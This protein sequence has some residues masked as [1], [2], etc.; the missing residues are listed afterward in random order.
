M[1]CQRLSYIV[2]AIPRSGSSLL[3]ELLGETGVAGAPAEYFGPRRMEKLQAEWGTVGLDRYVD[4]LR[5]RN[6]GSNGVFGFK[7]HFTQL[8]AAFGEAGAVTDAFP[9]LRFVSMRRGD[10]VRQAVSYDRAEQTGR[11]SSRAPAP[12][13]EP[14]FDVE[15]IERKVARIRRDQ[16]LW[17]A[18]FDRGG[19]NPFR[20]VYE[21]LVESPAPTVRAVLAFLGLALPS[22]SGLEAPRRRQQ[23]DELS[24]EWVRRYIDLRERD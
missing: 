1:G 8:R 21:E 15:R 13:S 22:G 19:H 3:C 16:E 17:D 4:E 9:D 6:S 11:W 14:R 23:A 10:L 12:R 5:A 24:E 20:V 7:A 18:F 2:C